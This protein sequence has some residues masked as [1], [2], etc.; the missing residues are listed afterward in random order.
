MKQI[1]LNNKIQIPSIGYGVFRMT[2]EE[3]C[4]QAVLQA[5]KTG[6]RFIDTA[7]AYGNEE[8]VGRA[9]HKCGVPRDELFISTKLWIPDTTYEN[10]KKGF[11]TS[12]KKLGLDYVDLYFIHQPYNDYYGA[13]KALVELY[14]EGKIRAL[15]LDNFTEER[16]A[17]F[18]FFNDT[19]PTINFVECNPFY[20]REKDLQYLQSKN[21]Q[22][23]AWSPLSAGENNI[24]ENEVL[25]NIASKYNKSIA[26]VVLRWLVQRNIIPVVKSVNP[27]RMKENLNIFDFALDDT[28]MNAIAT[29]ET[30]HSCFIARD[31][32][33][34]VEH[35]LSIA[36]KGTAPTEKKY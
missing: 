29:L 25:Q 11:E 15:G 17:D 3:E 31:N 26:Q 27:G 34:A 6:Y 20:Q 18:L 21:I 13:W 10:A 7:A 16:L 8:A 14:K 22:M 23:L 24:F 1:T 4:E 19:I 9:I 32:A 28:D 33:Q 35:F 5:I 30:G 36:T 12:L 2:N